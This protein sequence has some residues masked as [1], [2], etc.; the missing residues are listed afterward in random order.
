LGLVSVVER[1]KKCLDFT[2][3]TFAVHFLVC[4]CTFGIPLSLSWWVVMLVTFVLMDVLGEWLCMRQELR[5]IPRGA[6]VVVAGDWS[7]PV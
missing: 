7:Q 3:T 4:F 5:E 6:G 2:V 1:S